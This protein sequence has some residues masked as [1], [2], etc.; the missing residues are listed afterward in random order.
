MTSSLKVNLEISKI[1][2]GILVCK[3]NLFCEFKDKC[4][5][6]LAETII[7]IDSEVNVTLKDIKEMHS[8][9]SS[10]SQV[11]YQELDNFNLGN[12]LEEEIA[13]SYPDI[14]K[15]HENCLEDE[16]ISTEEKNLPFKKIRD[17]ME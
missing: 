11:H 15:C 8:D 13:I 5:N 17:L 6:C 1:S 16:S 14:V 12:F 3:G 2:A 4:Q 9:S 7:F 10:D